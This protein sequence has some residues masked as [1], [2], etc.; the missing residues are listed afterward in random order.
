MTTTMSPEAK[1]LEKMIAKEAKADESNMN[2]LLKDLKHADKAAA[3]AEK[4]EQHVSMLRFPHSSTQLI[5]P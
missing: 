2:H 4:V 5:G 1:Q 3:K